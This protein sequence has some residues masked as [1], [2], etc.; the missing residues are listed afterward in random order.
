MKSLLSSVVVIFQGFGWLLFLK[1]KMVYKFEF[2]KELIGLEN[3][4]PTFGVHSIHMR[5]SDL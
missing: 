2:R 3:I 5:S 4:H 1:R